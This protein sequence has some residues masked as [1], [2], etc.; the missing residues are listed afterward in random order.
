MQ[1]KINTT[2]EDSVLAKQLLPYL[3]EQG[4]KIGIESLKKIVHLICKYKDY[5][6]PAE[7]KDVTYVNNVCI[8]SAVFIK[9]AIAGHYWTD[10]KI[11]AVVKAYRQW[12]IT[13]MKVQ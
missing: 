5:A 4:V 8:L 2:K 11:M 13:Q 3:Q 6:D 1:T 12:K 9:G 7:D 10:E